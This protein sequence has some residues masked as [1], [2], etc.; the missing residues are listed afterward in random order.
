MTLFERLK[1]CFTFCNSSNVFLKG[2]ATFLFIYHSELNMFGF[3]TSDETKQGIS[4]HHLFML[5]IST[6]I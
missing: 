6:I 2:I 1:K 4:R 5:G 3:W